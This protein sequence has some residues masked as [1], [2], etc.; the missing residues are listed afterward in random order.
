MRHEL[1]APRNHTWTMFQE[2]AKCVKFLLIQKLLLSQ[3]SDC[4]DG[5]LDRAHDHVRRPLLFLCH[6]TRSPA[7]S[8]FQHHEASD[9][10]LDHLAVGGGVSVW[11]GSKI[12]NP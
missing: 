4:G 11:S 12:S 3:G 10:Q 8:A 7:Y 1:T 9:E 2:C 6:Q 5:L